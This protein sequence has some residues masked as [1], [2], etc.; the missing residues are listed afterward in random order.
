[1]NLLKVP[2]GKLAFMPGRLVR[3]NEVLVLLGDNWFIERSTKQSCEIIDRRLLGIEKH[4]DK[5][6]QEMK[7]FTDQLTWTKDLIKVVYG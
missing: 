3:T 4:L 1:M 6:K 5:L 7:I 2:F